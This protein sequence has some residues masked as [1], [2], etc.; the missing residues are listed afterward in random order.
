MKDSAD[1]PA[2]SAKFKTKKFDGK[3]LKVEVKV[4]GK[5]QSLKYTLQ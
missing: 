3:N 4:G 1:A 5:K 2:M